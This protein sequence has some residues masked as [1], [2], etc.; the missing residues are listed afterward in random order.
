MAGS[1]LK[2][3]PKEKTL[4]E[5]VK[6]DLRKRAELKASRTLCALSVAIRMAKSRRKPRP[7]W[8]R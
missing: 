2:K 4:V 6:D 7:L 1:A 5:K 8:C 3:V